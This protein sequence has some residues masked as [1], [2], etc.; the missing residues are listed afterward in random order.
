MND[1][2]DDDDDDDDD[3]GASLIAIFRLFTYIKNTSRDVTFVV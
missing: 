3:D 1:N 2:D